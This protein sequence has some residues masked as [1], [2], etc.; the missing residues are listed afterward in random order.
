[1]AE[2]MVILRSLSWGFTKHGFQMISRTNKTAM[3]ETAFVFLDNV[4][5]IWDCISVVGFLVC[6]YVCIYGS[7]RDK[8]P[9][10][11][12]IGVKIE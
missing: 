4:N 9:K 3:M 5:V 8:V 6:M 1:M 10:K 2:C 7:G 12:H 11:D